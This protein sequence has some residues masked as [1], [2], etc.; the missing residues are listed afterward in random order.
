[1]Q[2]A[3]S[4]VTVGVLGPVVAAVGG[5]EADL[6]GPR[7]RAVLARLAVAGGEVVSTDRLVHDLW[8]AAEA[9]AKAL[10][11][12][13]VHVSHLRRALEP[14][15]ARR[16]P[17]TVLVSAAP[18]YALR[19]GA[20]LDARRFEDLVR[21][22]AEAGDAG[23][24]HAALTAALGCWRGGAYAEVADAA[25]AAPEAARLTELRLTAVEAR[26]AAALDLGRAAGA[27]PELERHLHDHP[28]REEAVRL[29]ALALY[30][31][32]RQGDALGVLR[33][34]REH[35]AEELG[36]DPGP[37]LRA[38]EADVLAQAPT[39]DGPA[40]GPAGQSTGRDRATAGTTTAGPAPSGTTTAGTGEGA[41]T[42]AAGTT[43]T[44]TA[45]GGP[46]RPSMGATALGRAAEIA[47]VQAAADEAR[48]AGARVV[49]VVGEAG[50]GKTTLAEA[51]VGELAG[52]GW[53]VARG[54]CPEVAGAPPGWA[55]S[56]VVRA[57]GAPG[58][59]SE[60][61]LAGL[62]P[63]GEPSPFRL[64]RAV[65]A[66]IDAAA[67]VV[68][69][70]DDVH[71][72]DDLTLQLLRQVLAQLAGRP[73]LV[74]ATYRGN[75]APDELAAAVGALLGAT[76]A[77]LV[78][79]GLDPVAVGVLAREQ[80]LTDADPAVLAALAERTGGNPLFVRE[81]A[82]LI[83]AEG[84]RAAHTVVPAGVRETLRR[85]VARLPG[86][87]TT[88]LRQAAVLGRD[89]DV[90]VLA[91]VAGR[92]PDDLLD[93]LEVAVLAG[94]LDEPAPGR[95]RFTH[96]LVR[97]TLYEDTP[98]LRRA[99]LH[100]AA[101]RVLAGTADAATLAHHAEAAAGPAT[102]HE[103]VPYA[104][105]AAREA[106]AVGAWGEA[107]RRWASALR[108]HELAERR[109]GPAAQQ[110]EA[111]VALLTP[112]VTALAR[113][114]DTAGARAAYVRAVAAAQG[115]DRLGVL[116]AW[117]AP[118]VWTTRANPEPD[119]GVLAAAAE[120]L[121]EPDLPAATRVR[122][123][124]ALFREHEGHDVPAA[125]AVTGEALALARTVDDPRLLCLALNARAYTAL[126][127]DLRDERRALEDELVAVA[128]A[129]GEVDHEAVAHW[130]L[131]LEA[132]SR[133]D[134]A[135]ARA[136]MT[137]AVARAGTGQLGALLATVAIFQALLEVLAGRLDAAA[138][139]YEEV[140]R[141]LIEHGAV[142]GGLMAMVGR[143][144]V[145]VYRGD[146]SPLRPELEYVE[147]LY[148]GG[149]GEL[150]ALALLD[151]GR[152]DDARRVW[153]ARRRRVRDYY[154]LGFTALRAH[155]AGRLGD[156]A[157]ARLLYDEL[158][159]YAGRIAGL[160]SGTLYAGPVD[161][162]LAA[163][164]EA[165]GRPEE[166]ARRRAAAAHLR[167]QVAA[168]LAAPV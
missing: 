141:R 86:P 152:E 123:L 23:Q 74:V 75:E 3:Q 150:V 98:L 160:D 162:A 134:L 66:V 5:C 111:L 26:A 14:G 122:L 71:R 37:A 130:L 51:A 77:H 82:R 94:L 22:A 142:N 47:A 168:A 29:L 45:A 137:L 118:L 114:G 96:A 133:T 95:V 44:G 20:G 120:F 78:L 36:V 145:A 109:A 106:Q 117:D 70:L 132:A 79:G 16:A 87:A 4:D 136:E 156:V 10:A 64:G 41:G 121:A 54:R 89:V 119:A 167:E 83:T 159:P 108:L 62:L 148:P 128:A 9:P 31:T 72:G 104:V 7:P 99:R 92:D 25:W 19:V 1:M 27:V 97:D 6:G 34:A 43:A 81:L 18:G 55:W 57:L 105:A 8:D 53:R 40:P 107:A 126:G 158:L 147:S 28:G 73:L 112:A 61:A 143:I 90:D 161:D 153:A 58:A 113:S 139:R 138:A 116:C 11:V 164:A 13:Q 155:V 50:G 93:A 103:A 146:L 69:L 144:G 30:R 166:A 24:R 124:L 127:P 42:T 100:T 32:G 60:D 151:E 85:R 39:L 140:S 91:E 101:L 125:I 49:W 35:L 163:L 157:E 33:R 21:S 46:G 135:A 17:A 131:F 2:G 129:A 63:E 88:A 56:E 102:A 52:A 12:L 67:P 80:G 154:W 110:Q 84:P 76:A 38:L 165:L 48:R 15:R 149:M 65:A 59:D 115:R 68:V